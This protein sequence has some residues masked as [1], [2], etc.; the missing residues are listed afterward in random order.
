MS[1]KNVCIVESRRTRDNFD[2]GEWWYLNN[3]Y[4]IGNRLNESINRL[5]LLMQIT[6]SWRLSMRHLRLS[7]LLEILHYNVS[8]AQDRH[9][10]SV[11]RMADCKRAVLLLR[12][13]SYL[14]SKINYARL[15]SMPRGGRIFG[16]WCAYGRSRCCPLTKRR[17]YAA[18]RLSSA[19]LATF[20]SNCA[21]WIPTEIAGCDGRIK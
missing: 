4:T 18:T 7:V 11:P 8:E 5:L 20:I 16:D 10:L 2:R 1:G 14:K 6:D 19:S 17:R 3:R 9:R 13:F 12:H 15:H 21:R